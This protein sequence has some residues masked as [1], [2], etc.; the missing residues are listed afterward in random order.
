MR[1]ADPLETTG[2]DAV[3]AEL[4][5]GNAPAILE[6]IK[7]DAPRGESPSAVFSLA[8]DYRTLGEA[9]YWQLYATTV[10]P[11]GAHLQR[12][13]E[14]EKPSTALNL[15][16]RVLS[17]VFPPEAVCDPALEQDLF[18]DGLQPIYLIEA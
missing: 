17:E 15:L 13:I 8:F 7:A 18:Y 12:G 6:A 14:P 2:T 1:V 4:L 10:L 9:F 3:I 11:N 5:L 16:S